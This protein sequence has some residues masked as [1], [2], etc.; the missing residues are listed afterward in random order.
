MKTRL[1]DIISAASVCLGLLVVWSL[2]ILVFQLPHYI[3]PSPSAVMVAVIQRFPS[4]LLSLEITS[5]AAAGGWLASIIIGILV[6][7]IFA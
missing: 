5:T 3:L 7:I 2:S 4:L 1:I 6:A